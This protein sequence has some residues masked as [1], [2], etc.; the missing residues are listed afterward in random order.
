MRFIFAVLFGVMVSQTA[1]AQT[2]G[3]IAQSGHFQHMGGPSVV[4][5]CLNDE[6]LMWCL[7]QRSNSEMVRMSGD[8]VRFI[9]NEAMVEYVRRGGQ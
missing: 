1:L 6:N 8:R 9:P 7:K 5:G 4:A 2:S 3:G